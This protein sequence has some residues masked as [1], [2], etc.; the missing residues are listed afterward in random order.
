MLIENKD[1]FWSNIYHNICCLIKFL[2]FS[3][4][5]YER[6]FIMNVLF[7]WCYRGMI[8]MLAA[9]TLTVT[10][11]PLPYHQLR[12]VGYSFLFTLF[13]LLCFHSCHTYRSVLYFLAISY[14]EIQNVLDIEVSFLILFRY[15]QTLLQTSISSL[16]G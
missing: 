7:N 8:Y 2:F 13:P 15:T 1:L 11:N 4:H 5:L 12:S 16:R 3:W 9:I 10:S 6:L 14:Y